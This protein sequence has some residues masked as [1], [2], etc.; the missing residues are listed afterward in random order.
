MRKIVV[1]LL[2]SIIISCTGSRTPA[3]GGTAVTPPFPVIYS[4][5]Y[6]IALG[7][8]E[9]YHPFDTAKY[10]KVHDYL[11]EN[12]LLRPEDFT[13]P[14]PVTD[15][16]LLLVHTR[17]YLDSLADPRTAARIAEVNEV[18]YFPAG[19]IEAGL[20]RPMRYAVGGTI[21]GARLALERGMAV[22]L[23][24][25][26][27]H[28]KADSGGGFC[29]FSDIAVAITLLWEER[30]DLK[31]LI[32]DLDAHQGNGY[33]AIF[34]DDPRIF[35][36]DAYNRD[37]YPEDRPARKYV[38]FPVELKSDTDTKTYLARVE[39]ALPLALEAADPGIIIYNAGTD[40]Y[41]HDPLGHLAVSADGIIRRDEL[42]FREAH[43]R[44]VPLLM[45]LAG[46][47]TGESGGIIARSIANLLR[48]G[49]SGNTIQ[50]M[51]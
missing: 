20:Y 44:G 5:E 50:G 34:T 41:E 14:E 10:A 32:V 29:Y 42:V 43:G 18:A 11:V 47:Y 6:N 9:Q 26:F 22:N 36:L 19:M 48:L 16:Q 24:G 13:I 46:G 49:S 35:I 39:T 38:D 27:H 17:A 1:L 2:F 28:A 51:R 4:P 37:I 7:G 25:G 3:P 40:I 33:A 15:D 8:I 30:P 12:H 21:L 31:V 23:S 45:L